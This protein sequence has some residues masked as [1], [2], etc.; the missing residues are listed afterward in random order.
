MNRLDSS[1][2]TAVISAL[3]EGCSVRSTARLTGVSKPTVLRLLVEAG[4]VASKLQDYMFRNLTCKRV[5]VDEMWA[6]IGAKQKN[7]TPAILAK[8]PDAGD[9]WLW[10]AID[11]DTKIVPSWM[12][13]GRDA[14]V[15]SQFLHDLRRRLASRVQLS[16]DGHSAYLQAVDYAWGGMDL[17]YAQLIKLYGAERAGEARYSPAE[18]IGCKPRPVIGNPDPKHISTSFAERQNLSVRMSLRRYTRL[19]NAFSRKLENHAAAV[20]LYYFSYNFTKIHRTLRTTPAMAAGVADRLWEV[21]DLV[22]LLESEESGL[23]RAA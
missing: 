2:R 20:A 1:K 22:A 23:G 7:V 12:L 8:N 16:S 9:I 21:S 18:C 11:A 4:A 14:G 6:F 17:D 15:A 5:Q 19:T 3:V 13:G 10:V